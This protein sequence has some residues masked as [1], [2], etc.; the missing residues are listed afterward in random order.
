MFYTYFSMVVCLMFFC[1]RIFFSY[2][3]VVP[4]R[5]LNFICLCLDLFVLLFL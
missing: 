3:F 4:Q 2:L 5:V 1:E